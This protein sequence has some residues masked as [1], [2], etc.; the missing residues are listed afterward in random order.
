MAPTVSCAPSSVSKDAYKIKFQLTPSFRSWSMDSSPKQLGKFIG[1]KTL[2]G[3][4]RY[5]GACTSNEKAPMVAISKVLGVL[6]CGLLLCLEMFNA[7]PSEHAPAPS[8]LMKTD[9]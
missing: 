4:Y 3:A 7:A 5:N 9:A 2:P 6:S 1:P 8:D